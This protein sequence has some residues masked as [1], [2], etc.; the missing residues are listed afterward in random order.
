M[1]EQHSF[2]L[3][4]DYQTHI[5]RLTLEQRGVLL[6]AVFAHA[7][8]KVEPDMDA[9][10]GMA[11]SFIAAQLDR[12]R[13]KWERTQRSRAEA[14]HKG[15]VASGT[16]RKQN[17][18]NEASASFVKQTKANEADT[19][20]VTDTVT[21]TV[22]GTV[23][24][25]ATDTEKEST[26]AFGG[27]PAAA[28]PTLAPCSVKPARI[29]HGQYGWVKLTDE[30]YSRLSN[31]LGEPEVKR[32]IAYVDESAQSNGNKN[33]WRDWNLVLRKCARNGWG[34][35]ETKAS[36]IRSRDAVKTAADYED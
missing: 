36:P 10:T 32:C 7:S 23:T 14:G 16:V 4:S 35:G 27:P 8:A 15:G 26:G 29:K 31:D 18:A 6:T 24:D 5:D 2:V 20:T 13:A 3:Y 33:K 12:D 30:E 25:T 34:K 28:P 9:A 17:E 22:T 19:V 21:D 1:A 11:F